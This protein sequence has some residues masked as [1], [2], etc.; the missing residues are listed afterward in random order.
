[1]PVT[2]GRLTAQ[3]NSIA[4]P[5]QNTITLSS[6]TN[7]NQLEILG[8]AHDDAADFCKSAEL[9]PGLETCGGNSSLMRPP[10]A[11][12]NTRLQSGV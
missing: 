2:P 4:F 1:M 5:L 7:G 11:E 10:Q 6:T 12:H 3:S 8:N 9:S